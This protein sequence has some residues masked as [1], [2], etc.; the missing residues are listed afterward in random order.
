MLFREQENFEEAEEG[1]RIKVNIE[2]RQATEVCEIVRIW[3]EKVK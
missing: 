3:G 1:G 2:M